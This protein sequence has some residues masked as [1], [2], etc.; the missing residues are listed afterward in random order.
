FT[1][2]EPEGAG[3][4]GHRLVPMGPC[5]SAW[6]DAHRGNTGTAVMTG[7][8]CAV[9]GTAYVAISPVR[10]ALLPP[11]PWGSLMRTPGWAAH[12]TPRLGA[13]CGRQD[14]AILPYAMASGRNAHPP[15]AHGVDPALQ[16]PAR[17]RRRVH[18]PSPH[19]P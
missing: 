14:H 3:K 13:S 2:F 19:E 17:R 7:L 8:P 12:I 1:L 15:V 16:P 9:V 6:V 11:S 5:A 18:R 4:T 10:R